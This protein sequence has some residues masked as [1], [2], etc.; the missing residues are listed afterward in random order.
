MPA[1][2]CIGFRARKSFR[3]KAAAPPG[4]RGFS[5][6]NGRD[7]EA[8]TT[9]STA[10][11]YT[12]AKLTQSCRARPRTQHSRCRCIVACRKS[13]CRY[14]GR[15]NAR[16]ARR[17]KNWDHRARKGR[18]HRKHRKRRAAHGSRHYRRPA[19]P[20]LHHAGV[21]QASGGPRAGRGRGKP[22]GLYLVSVLR[23]GPGRGD[24]SR[25][26]DAPA[27]GEAL[28][29]RSALAHGGRYYHPARDRRSAARRLFRLHLFR[30][31][32]PGRDRTD[33]L[34]GL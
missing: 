32:E 31:S 2:A 22:V 29:P 25:G 9:T 10:F 14:G 21:G 26:A 5:S 30:L 12:R 18:K 11:H 24:T 13:D 4:E 33:R 8:G 19:Y 17:G 6:Q 16:H 7:A 1:L 28:A 20:G 3:V 27:G 23:A 34:L 15:P